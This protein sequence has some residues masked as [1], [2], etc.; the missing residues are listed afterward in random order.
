M[1]TRLLLAAALALTGPLSAVRAD[2]HT[3]LNASYDVARELFAQV[4]AAFVPYWKAK[5]GETA[6]INQSHGGSSKQARSV[7]DGLEADVVTLNQSTDIQILADNGLVSKDWASKLPDKS[8]PYYSLISFLVRKGNP[9]NIRDWDD[10]AR[11]DVKIIFPNPKTSGNGRYTYLAAWAY[12]NEKFKGDPAQTGAFLAKLVGNVPV[13][14]TGGRG[15]TTTFVER[16]IGDVLITFESETHGISKEFGSDKFDI[17]TPPTSILADFP[18]AVVTKVAAKHG[19]TKLAEG[20]LEFLYTPEG[21]EIIARNYNR[22]RNK[23]VAA[24]YASQFP[25][26]KLYTIDETFGGW[27][28]AEKT[29]FSDTGTFNQAVA[30]SKH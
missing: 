19:T 1:K 20:Y 27:A 28:N 26:V 25:E 22:V 10:L 6:V 2:D 24:K 9:K 11:S 5:T 3:L 15:A 29:H 12:A 14:D 16:G 18:V 13:F 4:N 23:E 17:V 21:Q 7:L 30:A 8:S